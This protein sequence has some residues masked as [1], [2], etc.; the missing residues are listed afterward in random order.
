[1]GNEP[2]HVNSGVLY[3]SSLL[4]KICICYLYMYL[5]SLVFGDPATTM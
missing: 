4:A 3:S 5:L 1:M 2:N